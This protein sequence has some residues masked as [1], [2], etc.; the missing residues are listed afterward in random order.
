MSRLLRRWLKSRP[1]YYTLGV[2]VCFDLGDVS[3]EAVCCAV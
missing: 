3:G 1:C 2:V